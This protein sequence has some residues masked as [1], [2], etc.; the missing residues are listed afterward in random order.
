[1]Y[2]CM[3]SPDDYDHGCEACGEKEIKLDDCCEIFDEIVKQLYSAEKLNKTFLTNC[4]EEL[5]QKLGVEIPDGPI[6]LERPKP[7]EIVKEWL[8]N[9]HAYTYK[10]AQ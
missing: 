9:S 5:A 4:V 6:L 2:H 3:T 8:T 10:L 7:Q 1:M